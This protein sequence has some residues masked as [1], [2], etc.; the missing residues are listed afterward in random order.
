M[1]P[2]YY[3][4]RNGG[5]LFNKGH[6]RAR[7]RLDYPA[8]RSVVEFYIE[9]ASR[10]G[11]QIDVDAPSVDIGLE[12]IDGTRVLAF[13]GGKDSRLILGVLRELGIEPQLMT[14]GSSPADQPGCLITRSIPDAQGA[15]AS[16]IMPVLMQVPRHL[17][18]GLGLGEAHREMPWQQYYDMASRRALTEWSRM[19]G[20][21]GVTIDMHT[22]VSVLPYNITQRILSAIPLWRRPRRASAPELVRRRTCTSASSNG[23]TAS[24][25]ATTVTRRCSKFCSRTS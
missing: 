23:S 5:P 20:S 4:T 22:P 14:A 2:L 11:L 24:I 17:Y 7:I 13:G 8:S 16:R 10:F 1:Y 6:D 15:L 12:P 19:F 9:R 25:T 3:L 18:L 21:L